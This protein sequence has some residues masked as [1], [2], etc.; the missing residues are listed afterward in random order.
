MAIETVSDD[1]IRKF[2]EEWYVALDRH[3]P[4]SRVEPFLT[5]R[6]LVM[7]FPEGTFRGLEQFRGWYDKVI[8]RFFDERHTVT[9]VG[10]QWRPDGTA[11]VQVVVNWQARIWDPPA[12]DSTWLGFDAYQTW[13]VSVA[14]GTPRI[15]S[16][17]VDD[18][19]PMPGSA[20]L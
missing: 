18:L 8:N 16:Y 9:E 2:V 13:V 5:D 4:L 1:D 10:V 15:V 3:E 12:P 19:A 11:T 17:A 6:D 14:E 7:V 20:T